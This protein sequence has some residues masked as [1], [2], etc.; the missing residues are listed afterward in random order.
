M[1]AFVAAE[2]RFALTE[3]RGGRGRYADKKLLFDLRR[4]LAAMGQEVS[5]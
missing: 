1:P 5:Q 3:E 2:Q 4:I